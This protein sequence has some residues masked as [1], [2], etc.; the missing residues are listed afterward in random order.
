MKPAMFLA[1]IAG[2][3]T[4]TF[5]FQ[6][7]G[8]GLKAAASPGS[9]IAILAMTPKDSYLG[10]LAGVAAGAVVSFIIAAIILKHDRSTADEF[11]AKQQEMAQMKA[12]SKGQE[13]TAKLTPADFSGIKKIIFACDAGMGSSA[14]G[15]SLLRD[16]V[17]KA[18]IT[19]VSVTNT[20]VSR[21][22]DEPDLLV[23]TQEELAERA[24]Q[25]T[26][27]AVHVQVGN[28]LNSPRY[29]EII[30]RLKTETLINEETG[31]APKATSPELELSD[32][33]EINFIRHDQNVGTSTMAV[34]L[35]KD[36]LHKAGKKIPV[37]A[38][39]LDELVDSSD[40][41]VIVT[42]EAKKNLAIRYTNVQVLAVSDLLTDEKL[43]RVIDG[44]A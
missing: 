31:V 26:P 35:F 27:S 36:S 4:G 10:V 40:H 13:T 32:V 24:A 2:G 3:V 42:K 16:K 22:Q 15:A 44:L 6:L 34:S 19:D 8:A 33:K 17:K 11:E 18:G 12:E 5:T 28:F 41:L 38:V 39:R 25:K 14:M 21:L 20:A 9:I 29:D 23:V 30:A 7:F 1:V 37:K 43:A